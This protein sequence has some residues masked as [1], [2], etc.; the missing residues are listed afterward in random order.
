MEEK[1]KLHNEEYERI[2]SEIAYYL[3][4]RGIR[5]IFKNKRELF[6]TAGR[7]NKIDIFSNSIE[8]MGTL[9]G[10]KLSIYCLISLQQGTQLGSGSGDKSI[11]I[12][13]MKTKSIIS[14]LYSEDVVT[15]L[16][17]PKSGVLV[18]GYRSGSLHIWELFQELVTYSIR[19]TLTRHLSAI[20]GIV[21]ISN[22]EIISGE[23]RGD[24]CI[25][26][27]EKGTCTK[28]IPRA[29]MSHSLHKIKM[30]EGLTIGKN[31]VNLVACCMWD[32]VTLGR[33]K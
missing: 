24:L 33:E 29:H 22:T 15:A 3:I 8:H 11:K 2:I 31:I 1:N 19:H 28:Q 16:C 12:W 21:T 18:S 32:R 14:T 13:D 26:N 20:R 30:L 5:P 9:R 6:S 10:H 17:Q 27:I 25:W 7:D 23:H 4:G